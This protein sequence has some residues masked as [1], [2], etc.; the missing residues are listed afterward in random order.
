M[1]ILEAF[2]SFLEDQE[3]RSAE[4][5]EGLPAQRAAYAQKY[6]QAAG[7]RDGFRESQIAG[8]ERMVRGADTVKDFVPVVGD[9][10]GAADF[11]DEVSSDD[12]NYLTAGLL[13]AG[14][15]AGTVPVAGDF[16]QKGLGSLADIAKRIEIDPNTLGMSGGNVKLRAKDEPVYKFTTSHG[17]TYEGFSDASTKRNRAARPGDEV[18]GERSG[19][20]QRTQKTVFMTP[21]DKAE[22]QGLFRNTE[23]PVRFEPS[24]GKTNKGRLV[25]LEDYGPKPAGTA[26]TRDIDF[27]TRPEVGLHP[28]EFGSFDNKG[29]YIT[30]KIND[31]YFKYYMEQGFS[32][33]DAIKKANKIAPI[34]ETTD[35]S[36]N[37]HF[38]TPIV[39]VDKP[40]KKFSDGGVAQLGH[41]L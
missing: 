34:G 39:S 24:P 3:Q 15:I 18:K 37:I 12:P 20:Q 19:P 27:T 16:I 32:E 7:F 29:L 41:Y 22:W 14:V 36:K 1:S 30:E 28:I 11:V 8:S 10:V 13:G 21:E 31:R 38:G 9:I 23:V 33:A 35:G 40:V 26:M 4:I 6:P 25:L 2:R 17:S 5:A